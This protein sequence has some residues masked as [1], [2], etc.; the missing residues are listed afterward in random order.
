[1]VYDK[2][3]AKFCCYMRYH[4]D[5]FRKNI[6]AIGIPFGSAVSTHITQYL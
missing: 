6:K 2:I 4:I 3:G 5:I 1:M